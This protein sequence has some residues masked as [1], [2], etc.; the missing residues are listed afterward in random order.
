MISTKTLRDWFLIF[1]ALLV[2]P[3]ENRIAVFDLE[4]SDLYG[5]MIFEGHIESYILAKNSSAKKV[6]LNL[7]GT[8]MTM[9]LQSGQDA[10]RAS[11]VVEDVLPRSVSIIRS[12]VDPTSIRRRQILL[13]GENYF[14]PGRLSVMTDADW[15]YAYLAGGMIIGGAILLGFLIARLG[16]GDEPWPTNVSE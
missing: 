3:E 16:L 8:G 14:S 1:F 12:S 15:Y 10:A 11:N 4:P 6:E 2:L 7:G 13:G 5:E 9:T